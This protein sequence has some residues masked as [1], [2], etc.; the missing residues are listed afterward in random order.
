M[1]PESLL[2]E[3]NGKSV[4]K[5]G[6]FILP[7]E[8]FNLA[9]FLRDDLGTTW[10]HAGGLPSTLRLIEKLDFE[11]GMRVLD[12]GCGVGSATRYLARKTGCQVV[13]VDFDPEMIRR[14]REST[15]GSAYANVRYERMDVLHTDFPDASF[16]RVV[17]QSV[18][19]FNDKPALF[20]EVLRVLKPGGMVGMNE[21]T[22]LKPPTPQIEQVMCST[23]CETFRGAELAGE[24]VRLL[25]AAGLHGASAEAHPFNAST[26]YQILRE[27]G[28]V[29][30]LRIMW[31]VLTNPEINMRLS[32]MSELFRNCPEYFS[33]GIYTARKPS[34]R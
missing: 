33:Y 20:R 14:A 3:D 25:E 4:V 9:K 22:W 29:N 24:W 6:G 5:V 2:I 21:V 1:N 18:A 28:V 34:M 27:E 31:R 13:G 12:L 7:A 23:I 16:D 11:P 19:C 17:I 30:T 8:N 32:A 26:A 10:L 15:R